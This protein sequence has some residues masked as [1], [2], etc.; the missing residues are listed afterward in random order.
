MR[1][2]SDVVYQATFLDGE[3]RGMADFVVR[4]Q[5][6]SYEVIDTKLARH[7]RPAHVL[8]LCFYTEQVARIQGRFPDAMHVV[9]GT[10]ERESFRPGDY[11]AYY[12]RLRRRFL[13]PVAPRAESHPYPDEHCGICDF[14][15]P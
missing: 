1:A 2:G 12:R 9:A 10:G 7:A 11:M 8:Q 13:D 14:L 15:P 3:W 6:G 5:D 4:L